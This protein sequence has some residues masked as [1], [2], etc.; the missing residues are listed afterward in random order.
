MLNLQRRLLP[1]SSHLNLY[2]YMYLVL[3]NIDTVDREKGLSLVHSAYRVSSHR[4]YVATSHID[5]V[6]LYRSP[7]A[8]GGRSLLLVHTWARGGWGEGDGT[9]YTWV[10]LHISQS[11]AKTFP[12]PGRSSVETK[13]RMLL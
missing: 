8:V 10:V 1:S 7:I 3:I 12:V 4:R 5:K 9:H 6:W 11:R 13:P 2:R